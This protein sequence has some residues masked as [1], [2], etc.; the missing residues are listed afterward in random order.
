M[1]QEQFLWQRHTYFSATYVFKNE[2]NS[3]AFTASI[4][5]YFS[6]RTYF[7]ELAANQ[8]HYGDD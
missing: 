1:H 6:S 8:T 5:E 2:K 4:Q 7:H 3:T